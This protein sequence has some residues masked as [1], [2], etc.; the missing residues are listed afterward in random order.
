MIL[1]DFHFIAKINCSFFTSTYLVEGAPK[2]SLTNHLMKD[3]NNDIR[4]P[5]NNTSTKVTMDIAIIKIILVVR[6]IL[7]PK[8]FP[9]NS[10]ICIG[11]N[12]NNLFRKR[13]K[14]LLQPIFG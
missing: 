12:H 13:K 2:N 10:G 1:C 4:P 8:R 11:L 9:Q 14:K 7:K 5:S 3:Y 6:K